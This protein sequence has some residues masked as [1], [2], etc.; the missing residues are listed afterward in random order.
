MSPH[1]ARSPILFFKQYYTELF[2]YDSSRII[3][4]NI[5]KCKRITPHV[6]KHQS[7]DPIDLSLDEQDTITL[8]G[9]PGNGKTTNILRFLESRYKT[10]K[11][12]I[13][14]IVGSLTIQNQDLFNKIGRNE[15]HLDYCNKHLKFQIIHSLNI[16]IDQHLN[17]LYKIKTSRE[18]IEHIHIN[19][20]STTNRNINYPYTGHT[21]TYVVNAK[22]LQDCQKLPK[23]DVLVLDES[24]QISR[25]LIDPTDKRLKSLYE[26]YVNMVTEAKKLFISDIVFD[27]NFLKWIK[28]IRPRPIK[29]YQ[30]CDTNMKFDEVLLTDDV[31]TTVDEIFSDGKN[32][33]T[34]KAKI[35]LNAFMI[36]SKHSFLIR[37]FCS[38]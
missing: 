32:I 36:N 24:S 25:C 4:E 26:L 20:R 10:T 7:C 9:H 11:D 3:D 14:C 35:Y 31:D 22:S 12:E 1:N 2:K 27:E 34:V 8:I 30:I 13:H 33:Y 29:S 28:Q 19:E 6:V 16:R 5:E 21:H 15:Q 23:I 17:Y 18:S 37:S 38:S